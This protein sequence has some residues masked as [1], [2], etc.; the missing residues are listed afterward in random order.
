MKRLIQAF[1]NKN[2]FY[3]QNKKGFSYIGANVLFGIKSK[4]LIGGGVS[5]ESFTRLEEFTKKYCDMIKSQDEM[6]QMLTKKDGIFTGDEI[7]MNLQ[8]VE[9]FVNQ[10]DQLKALAKGVID[11]LL[12]RTNKVYLPDVDSKHK[13]PHKAQNTT[14][15]ILNDI[16]EIIYEQKPGKNTP[17]KLTDYGKLLQEKFASEGFD[18]ALQLLDNQL[19]ENT[20]FRPVTDAHLNSSPPGSFISTWGDPKTTY[21]MEL[22]AYKTDLKQDEMIFCKNAQLKLIDQLIQDGKLN[23][24]KPEDIGNSIVRYINRQ[25]EVLV[26][27]NKLKSSKAIFMEKAVSMQTNDYTNKI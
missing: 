8:K 25:D 3:N 13:E 6:N 19:A 5:E 26:A 16:E 24:Y 23:E 4:C 12:Y 14:R 9:T 7:R 1:Q 20:G 27:S 17:G 11:D 21:V 2:Y 18:K 10:N 22:E 15:K